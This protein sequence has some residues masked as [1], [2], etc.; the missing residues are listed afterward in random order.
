[1]SSIPEMPQFPFARTNTYHPPS[2]NA[3][4][5]HNCPISKVKLFDGKEAWIL[6][7]R[8]D[9]CAALDSDKLSA[10]RRH[11]GYP[12]IHPGGAKAKEAR[13]T[14]VNLDDPEH[15]EQRG[16]LEPWFTPDAANKL[17]PMMARVV[18]ENLNNL[19]MKH[20]KHPDKP[21]EFVEE[22]AG[23]VPPQVVYHILGVPEEDIPWL[24]H[25]SEVRTSTSRN[26]A[27]TSN[28]NLRNYMK[29][30]VEK[31]LE[32]PQD[33]LISHLA[34]GPYKEGKLNNEDIVNLAFLVLVAGNA[35]LINAIA[36][37]IVTLLQNPDQ[38][39]ELKQTP[40]VAHKVVDELIRYHTTSALN[41]RRAVKEDMEI[42]GLVRA[43]QLCERLVA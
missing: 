7:K 29:E 28:N 10:D 5:R 1:M 30:L 18:E 42:G 4:L 27:E 40:S 33:D 43:E 25:D 16:M 21:V 13:P 24:S 11:P 15:A 6:M 20:G 19:I 31:R 38:L 34:K 32:N 37:G 26:A 3:E 8:K 39:N 2:E 41:S 36:L 12:E 9:V 22:F 17:R 14:F 35:A 23:L